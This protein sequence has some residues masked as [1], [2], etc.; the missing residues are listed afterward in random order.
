MQLGVR[1]HEGVLAQVTV[2]VHIV[3]QVAVGEPP[4]GDH[5][6]RGEGADEVVAHGQQAHGILPG[7]LPREEVGVEEAA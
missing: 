4:G 5:A 1:I 3:H 6:R 7:H 2:Q